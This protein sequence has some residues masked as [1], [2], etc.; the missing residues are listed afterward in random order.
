M[1]V[2]GVS[3]GKL[4]TTNGGDRL[5][6]STSFQCV[7]KTF[8]EKPDAVQ[9][10]VCT[11]AGFGCFKQH[12]KYY[13]EPH[14][15]DFCMGTIGTQTVQRNG[16]KIVLCQVYFCFVTFLRYTTGQRR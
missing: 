7:R 5:L 9:R 3:E 15:V 1:G 10:T 14:L 16:K 8:R 2:T 13:H 12:F 6:T 11:L 4:A